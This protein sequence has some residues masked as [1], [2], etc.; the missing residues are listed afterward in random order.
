MPCAQDHQEEEV[1]SAVR[2]AAVLGGGRVVMGSKLQTYIA[3]LCE[4]GVS[5]SNTSEPVK[6]T[7]LFRKLKMPS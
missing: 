1:Q 4:G 3:L 7:K 5:V 6:S 2:G